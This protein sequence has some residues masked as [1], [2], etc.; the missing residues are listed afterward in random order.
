MMLCRI[1][2][3]LVALLLG[4]RPTIRCQQDRLPHRGLSNCASLVPFLLTAT[5]PGDDLTIIF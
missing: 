1:R 3:S 5:N 4:L 2:D